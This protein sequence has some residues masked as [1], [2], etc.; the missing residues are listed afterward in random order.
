MI[1][2]IL[3]FQI[4]QKVTTLLKLILLVTKKSI[5]INIIYGKKP[6]VLKIYLSKTNFEL[7][8]V[9]LGT[10]KSE[11]KNLVN[12]SVIKLTSKNL[13]KPPSLGGE[14]D[15]AQFLQ[16]LPGVVFTGDQ[17]GKIIYKRRSPYS[18]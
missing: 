2:D 17:G 5:P 4:F 1:M 11:N 10:E 8:A 18:Q 16:I 9:D 14:V 3:F 12:S 13:E 15:L 6:P 7:D